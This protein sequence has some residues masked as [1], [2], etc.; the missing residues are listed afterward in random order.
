MR[1]TLAIYMCVYRLS[2]QYD[3]IRKDIMLALVCACNKCSAPIN[4]VRLVLGAIIPSWVRKGPPEKPGAARVL[5]EKG[6][7]L[8]GGHSRLRSRPITRHH[9]EATPKGQEEKG[10]L[11]GQN[12]RKGP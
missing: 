3:S 12:E 4:V 5:L 8:V 10:G 1:P 7:R 9:L 2:R 6:P 11:I